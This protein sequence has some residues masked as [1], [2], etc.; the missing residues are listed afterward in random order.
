MEF[1]D[2]P[3]SYRISQ[4]GIALALVLLM[5]SRAAL[6]QNAPMNVRIVVGSILG[7]IVL[8]SLLVSYYVIVRYPY[9]SL[10]QTSDDH[11]TKHFSMS[12]TWL[13][14][15]LKV[16]ST[17]VVLVLMISIVLQGVNDMKKTLVLIYLMIMFGFLNFMTFKYNPVDHPT[18]STFV[19]A[20]LGVGV[21]LFP[22]FIPAIFLGSVRCSQLLDAAEN[23]NSLEFGSPHDDAQM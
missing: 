23:E 22:F 6:N 14:S 21:L 19:R 11:F 8:F 13:Y 7:A 16:L 20:T 2:F 17:L 3:L 15:L 12:G 1:K 4:G 10:V 18:I 5:F 9:L